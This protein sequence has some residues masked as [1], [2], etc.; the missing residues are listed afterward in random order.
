MEDA[1]L[2]VVDNKQRKRTPKRLFLVTSFHDRQKQTLLSTLV[3]SKA[4]MAY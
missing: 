1:F 2:S 3:S 4:K